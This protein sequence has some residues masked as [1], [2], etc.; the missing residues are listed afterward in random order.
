M[1]EMAQFSRS[2]AAFV[3]FFY[4]YH[5]LLAIEAKHHF[6]LSKNSLSINSSRPFHFATTSEGGLDLCAIQL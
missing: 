2:R 6:K 5:V 4:V 3:I 1:S